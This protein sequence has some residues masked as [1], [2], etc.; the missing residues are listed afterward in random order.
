[1]ATPSKPWLAERARTPRARGWPASRPQICGV[2]DV[3]DHHRLG[4]VVD[5]RLERDEVG[6]RRARRASSRPTVSPRWGSP[7]PPWPGKCFTVTASPAVV[8][9]VGEG[10]GHLGHHRRGRHRRCDRRS[11]RRRARRRGRPRA[12][13]PSR[14]RSSAAS[15]PISPPNVAAA[16]G[17]VPRRARGPSRTGWSRAPIAADPPAFVVDGHEQVLARGARGGRRPA[18]APAPR[19]R[20]SRRGASPRRR[21][22]RRAG[23]RAGRS[24]SVTPGSPTT[25]TS[26]ARSSSEA[27]VHSVIAS[28]SASVR[29]SWGVRSPRP[30]SSSAGAPPPRRRR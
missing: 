2:G 29:A 14:R 25:S 21:R 5:Q 26:P 16:S 19:R 27:R 9:P 10:A 20:C 8:Q 4:A 7:S 28:P 18:P 24:A 3:A 22:R 17:P 13:T 30:R 1:M 23:R 11:R 6:R 12:R 15:S